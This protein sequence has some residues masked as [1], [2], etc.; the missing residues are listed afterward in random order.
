MFLNFKPLEYPLPS[1]FSTI[2][3]QAFKKKH[4]Y[5]KLTTT[6]RVRSNLIIFFYTNYYFKCLLLMLWKQPKIRHNGCYFCAVNLHDG[7]RGKNDLSWL[8]GTSFFTF[9]NPLNLLDTEMHAYSSQV[10]TEVRLLKR[11]IRTIGIQT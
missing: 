11:T 9:K 10:S 7:H 1:L 4:R 2:I 3:T 8:G 6:W 5:L